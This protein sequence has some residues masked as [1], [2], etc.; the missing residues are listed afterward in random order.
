[1]FS[2]RSNAGGIFLKDLNGWERL[3][4]PRETGVARPGSFSPDGKVLAYVMQKGAGLDIWIVDEDGKSAPRPL[5]DSP[6][7]EYLPMF[8]P[9]G[10]WLAYISGKSGK[11]EVYVRAYPDGDD[12]PV[13]AG[14]GNGLR[15]GPDGKEIFYQNDGDPAR[16][17]MKVSVSADARGI[18][19]GDPVKVLDLFALGG[20]GGIEQYRFGNGW[21]GNEYDI[22]PDGRRFVTTRSPDARSREIIIV[23]N[24]F[25]EFTGR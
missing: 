5:I 25:R 24:W 20:A 17:L 12:V 3:L 7:S 2:I 8:S 19:L 16:P 14:G 22:F 18:H 9:D 10:K 21:P 13:S 15:W 23:R 6:A 1:V 4:V 11:S